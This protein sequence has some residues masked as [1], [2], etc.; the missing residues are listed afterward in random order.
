MSCF[1]MKLLFSVP[2]AQLEAER[3]RIFEAV[4]VCLPD[5]RCEIDPARELLTV[6]LEGAIAPDTAAEALRVRLLTIGVSA[7]RVQNEGMGSAQ[8]HYAQPE[9]PPIDMNRVKPRRSVPLAAFIAVVLAV[10][11]LASICSFFVGALFVGGGTVGETLGTGEQNVEPYAEKIALIDEIFERYGLYD[12]DGQLLLDEMLK[13]YAA[14][15]GDR[16]AEYYTEEELKTLMS[17]MGGASVGIGVSVTM[18]VETGEILVI[19]VFPGSPAEGAG[20]RAGDRIT[21]IGTLQNGEKVSDLGYSVAMQKLLG[22]AGTTAQFVVLRDG[23]LIEFSIVRAKFTSVSVTGRVSTTNKSVGIVS[24]TQFD[25]NTPTQFKATMEALLANGCTRFVYDVRS[26]PGGEQKSVMAVLSYFLQENDVIMSVVSKDGSTTYYHAEPM[27]YDGEYAGCSV[28]KGEIGMYRDYPMVVL[29][30]GYT[31]SAGELFAAGLVDAGLAEV[32]GMKTY[33]KG[34]IQSIFDLAP[35]GY[36]GG[37]KLTVG[38]YAPPSGVNYDGVGITPSV[39]VEPNEHVKSK[40]VHL[41]TESEDNQLS[42]AIVA[43]L[44]K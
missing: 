16:Y 22:A 27:S 17:E 15:T 44:S 43:V 34:V 37:V 42:A 2:R 21:H 20:V 6:E 38:Y 11:V 8:Y 25:A 26:N 32:V 4:R 12:T 31:A 7:T 5:A 33:G 41:L 35:Y 9:M 1:S 23:E 36:K 29:T 30:N 10:A 19:Q 13:A 40:N 28:K 39:I 18:D 24:I 3:E 14:A